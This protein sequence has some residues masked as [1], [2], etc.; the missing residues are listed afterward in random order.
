MTRERRNPPEATSGERARRRLSAQPEVELTD[1]ELRALADEGIDPDDVRRVAREGS[2]TQEAS[3]H[4]RDT[5]RD[6]LEGLAIEQ[7]EEY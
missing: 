6:Q 3:E 7:E 2:D 1:E 4:D 5:A